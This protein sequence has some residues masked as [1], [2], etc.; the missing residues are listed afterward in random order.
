MFFPEGTR[1]TVEGNLLPFKRGAFRL[2]ADLQLPVLPMSI[3]GTGHLLPTGSV[4]WQP[5][6]VKLMIHPP[7]H[8]TDQLNEDVTTLMSQTEAAIRS[9]LTASAA[10]TDV[11]ISARG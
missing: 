9:G 6:P 2:A 10:E 4:K 7:I 8:T 3:S 1:G 5:G 11:P